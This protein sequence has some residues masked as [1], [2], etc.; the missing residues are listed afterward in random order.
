MGDCFSIRRDYASFGG[1]RTNGNAV[2]ALVGLKFSPAAAT[3]C[4][5]NW[6]IGLSSVHAGSVRLNSKSHAPTRCR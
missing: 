3:P 5:I 2:A 1:G 4:F 6:V